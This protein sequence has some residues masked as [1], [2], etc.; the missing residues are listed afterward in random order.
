MLGLW[1]WAFVK[2]PLYSGA[3]GCAQEFRKAGRILQTSVLLTLVSAPG[4]PFTESFQGSLKEPQGGKWGHI[5]AIWESIFW[6]S[7]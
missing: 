3:F 1:W 5:R 4:F 6:A 2:I 7:T